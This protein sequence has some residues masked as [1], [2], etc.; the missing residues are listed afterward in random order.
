MVRSKMAAVALACTAGLAGLAG[1]ARA[2]L[3]AGTTFQNFL[4][5][6]DSAN[7]GD[8]LSG[9]AIDGLATNEVILGIDFRPNG[10]TP[11]LYGLGSFG[12]LY[13]INT[14]TGVATRVGTT[15]FSPALNGSNFG[16]GFTPNGTTLRITS[17][18]DQNL[19]IDPVT[20]VVTAD[21]L[22]RPVAGDE[23]A[24]TNPNIVHL[25]YNSTTFFG[26]DTGRDRLVTMDDPN[27]GQFRTIGPLG[28][29][30]TEVGGFDWSAQSNT[31]YA[32][33]L[34][35]ASS[36]SQFGSVNLTTG[37]FTPLGEVGGGAFLTSMAAAGVIPAP[38]VLALLGLGALAIRRRR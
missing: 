7:P 15:P 19:R 2:E 27:N 16:F 32:T 10:A 31:A 17:N 12:R 38:G 22:L 24:T 18:A 3:I 13:T 6:W 33:F 9:V 21:A 37:V 28:F 30:A 36:R 35:S 4:I 25:G 8:I 26:I 29:D 23:G 34:N 5:T 14:T 20:A 1:Q 11:T